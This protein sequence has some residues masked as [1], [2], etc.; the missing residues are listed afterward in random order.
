MLDLRRP[1]QLDILT[2]NPPFY[3]KHKIS[4][5]S[6]TSW[7]EVW[8]L[9]NTLLMQ[10]LFY[11]HLHVY[12]LF[13]HIC[14]VIIIKTHKLEC[15]WT[16]YENL[17]L[18]DMFGLAAL[19]NFIFIIYFSPHFFFYLQFYSILWNYLTPFFYDWYTSFLR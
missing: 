16:S 18:Y 3:H 4:I 10:L 14:A 19:S 9:T 15:T 5:Y 2:K 1:W 8:H 11:I 6:F 7:L 12:Y 17:E 13:L